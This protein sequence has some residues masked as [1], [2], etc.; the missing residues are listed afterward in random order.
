MLVA[1]MAVASPTAQ[2]E[3]AIAEDAY[4]ILKMAIE[5][6]LKCTVFPYFE[7]RYLRIAA[8]RAYRTSRAKQSVDTSAD[9]TKAAAD[10]A[11]MYRDRAKATA[12][13][14]AGTYLSQGRGQAYAELGQAMLTAQYLRG[15]ATPAP[16]FGPLT[17]EQRQLF[18]AFAQAGSQAYGADWEAMDRYI[19]QVA[20][21]RM[22][23][24]STLSEGGRLISLAFDWD[25]AFATVRFQIAATTAGYVPRLQLLGN[26]MEGI[27]MD[28]GNLHPH[29]ILAA[30]PQK[31]RIRLLSGEPVD[32]Y[33]FLGIMPDGG[34]LV[35]VYG[36]GAATL[37]QGIRQRL[38]EGVPVDGKRYTEGCPF[39]ACF[40]IPA[41]RIEMLMQ[42]FNDTFLK[43]LV[44][45][46][47]NDEEL[48]TGGDRMSVSVELLAQALT[49]K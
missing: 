34:A 33:T 32:A 15:Q 12:C 27:A 37:P 24:L 46:W 18:G 28:A 3:D 6:D 23:E 39:D 42:S 16:G 41:D 17:D 5:L 31:V 8:N 10:V 49:E 40:R 45:E 47:P 22:Q 4:D 14:S 11:L 38:L 7:Q 35:A 20:T 36:E 43:S 9:P 13:E 48:E 29:L 1:A 25:I 19:Q 2:A 21:A 30:G 26:G 44:T